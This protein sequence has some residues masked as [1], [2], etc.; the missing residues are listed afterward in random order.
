MPLSEKTITLKGKTVNIVID[1]E[2]R[3]WSPDDDPPYFLG[4]DVCKR[5]P[6]FKKYRNNTK[7]FFQ[8]KIGPFLEGK[9]IDLIKNNI[10]AIPEKLKVI[11][12]IST[13]GSHQRVTNNPACCEIAI[14]ECRAVANFC[15]DV[16][17]AGLKPTMRSFIDQ[18]MRLH[19]MAFG[20][21]ND[22]ADTLQHEFLHFI[23]DKKGDYGLLV[24]AIP[25]LDESRNKSFICYSAASKFNAMYKLKKAVGATA[26]SGSFHD[27]GYYMAFFIGLAYMKN[28]MPQEFGKMEVLNCRK[29]KT[30]LKWKDFNEL[31]KDENRPLYFR[32]LPKDVIDIIFNKLIGW[33]S[34]KFISEYFRAAKALGINK[35]HWLVRRKTL[36]D[37]KDPFVFSS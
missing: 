16:M 31:L 1:F 33:S 3:T 37:P 10:N 24:E 9:I 36:P 17:P 14:N 2:R 18:N 23:K 6:E 22:V 12:W 26:E 19:R 27:I 35:E 30:G 20:G 5:V 25:I 15:V 32:N 8:D 13:R 4:D 7:M 28:E 21:W 29:E 11:I 34:R